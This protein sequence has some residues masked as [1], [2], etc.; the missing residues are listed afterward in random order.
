MSFKSLLGRAVGEKNPG[1]I[2]EDRPGPRQRT[3][4]M[5]KS[6]PHPPSNDRARERD[7]KP[8]PQAPKDEGSTSDKRPP[9][10][11]TE[12]PELG[13]GS[14]SNQFKPQKKYPWPQTN[15]DVESLLDQLMQRDEQ[16]FEADKE[17]HSRQDEIKCLKDALRD[18]ELSIGSF[19]DK[20]SDNNEL[21]KLKDGTIDSQLRR[22]N[23]RPRKPKSGPGKRQLEEDIIQRDKEIADLRA[24][25]NNI[26]GQFL[27]PSSEARWKPMDESAISQELLSIRSNIEDFA[28]DFATKEVNVLKPGCDELASRFAVE[29]DRFWRLPEHPKDMALVVSEIP[30]G[31]VRALTGLLSS[32]IMTD[33]VMNPFFF[34]NESFTA[35][36]RPDWCPSASAARY[37]TLLWT[38]SC[39]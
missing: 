18:V 27:R 13:A 14:K 32:A 20:D 3:S 37:L 22:T 38:A 21:R 29:L 5:S 39:D 36:L 33:V 25:L 6:R 10:S 1:A 23:D 8:L 26:Q 30:R 9:R 24:Q 12:E 31:A 17:S 2:G 4:S 16:L 15:M 28:H 11:L 34:V 35:G 7:R 19:S